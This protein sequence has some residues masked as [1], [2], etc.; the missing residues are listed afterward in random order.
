MM[1]SN[2]DTNGNRVFFL[3]PVKQ[4]VS[5]AEEFGKIVYLYEYQEARANVFTNKF[6]QELKERIIQKNFNPELDYLAL[7]G[8]QVN[9]AVAVHILTKMFE[10]FSVIAYHVPSRS[11]SEIIFNNHDNN[12]EQDQD[13]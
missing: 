1:N 2:N 4:E 9:I 12:P 7:T 8:Y 6:Q 13:E 10:E 3:E 5:D 11:Y